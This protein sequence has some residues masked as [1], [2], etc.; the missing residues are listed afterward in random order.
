MITQ[1][2]ASALV[3]WFQWLLVHLAWLQSLL[4]HL[5]LRPQF[6]AWWVTWAAAGGGLDLGGSFYSVSVVACAPGLASVLLVHLALDM[7]SNSMHVDDSG[8]W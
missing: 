6:N 2:S 4:V 5:A 3:G 1:S 7:V 8:R